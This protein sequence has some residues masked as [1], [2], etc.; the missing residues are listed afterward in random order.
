MDT[1][2]LEIPQDTIDRVD[3]GARYLD[4]DQ[5]GW[6]DRIDL[7]TLDMNN[8]ERCVLGQLG[9]FYSGNLIQW[10]ISNEATIEWLDERGFWILDYKVDDDGK[11]VKTYRQLTV[12]WTR[13]IEQRRDRLN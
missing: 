2:T 10:R 4:Q 13:L 8:V 9:T 7:D 5:P 12:E 1:D 6:H 3:R 11:G